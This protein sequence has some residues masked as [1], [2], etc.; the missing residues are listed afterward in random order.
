MSI[1]KRAHGS[2]VMHP[3]VHIDIKTN[4][5]NL[6]HMLPILISIHPHDSMAIFDAFP[7]NPQR[8]RSALKMH[9]CFFLGPRRIYPFIA[10]P[11]SIQRGGLSFRPRDLLDHYQ[12]GLYC[13][14]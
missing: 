6:S 14:V 10:L 9:P 1:A 11:I 4:N 12:M 13:P 3:H 7:L 2:I 5:K 8:T